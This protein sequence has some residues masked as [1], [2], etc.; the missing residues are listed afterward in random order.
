MKLEYGKLI[1]IN[2]NIY[3]AKRIITKAALFDCEA[4]KVQDIHV[5][6]GTWISRCINVYDLSCIP[7]SLLFYK[8]RW[9]FMNICT[10]LIF[11]FDVFKP[12]CYLQSSFIVACFPDKT[13]FCYVIIESIVQWKHAIM[14]YKVMYLTQMCS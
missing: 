14:N 9:L 5:H 6:V 13:P 2:L 8:F 3:T 12:K 11:D 4:Y 7:I 10:L 1:S